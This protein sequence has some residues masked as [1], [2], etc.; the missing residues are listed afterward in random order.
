[1]GDAFI[2]IT[3]RQVRWVIMLSFV[4]ALIVD[5]LNLLGESYLFLP[6]ITLLVLLYWCGHFLDQTYVSTAF[7][8]GLLMD[9]LF[10]S[11]L[12]IHALIFVLLT[13]A[14]LRHRLHF[15]GYSVLQQSLNMIGFLLLY[16]ILRLIVLAPPMNEAQQI[17]FWS[18]PLVG[19]VLWIFL[20]KGLNRLSHQKAIE[21]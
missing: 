15:R 19:G 1:M 4:L 2:Y 6:P 13:F 9:T 18:M 11:T 17:A 10:N 21:S 14:M 8:I 20:A 3:S 7:V 5:A 12:G 16:Q